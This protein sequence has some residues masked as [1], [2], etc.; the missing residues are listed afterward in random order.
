M[1]QHVTKT[2]HNVFSLNL[3]PIC[4][5][6]IIHI[7]LQ[8]LWIQWFWELPK[9]GCPCDLTQKQVS[10]LGCRHHW[11]EILVSRSLS[12]CRIDEHWEWQTAWE[13]CKPFSWWELTSVHLS[14]FCSQPSPLDHTCV[15]IT[16]LELLSTCVQSWTINKAQDM[17]QC[18]RCSVN[19]GDATMICVGVFLH[20]SLQSFLRVNVFPGKTSYINLSYYMYSQTL[21]KSQSWDNLW[22]VE[23]DTPF[24]VSLAFIY[25]LWS[26]HFCWQ[27]TQRSSSYTSDLYL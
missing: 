21:L 13:H 6:H 2:L 26:A 27:S 8:L 1:D 7:T 3:S 23:P 19:H 22:L 10:W 14:P 24:T 15:A 4:T 17:C 11:N 5:Y 18:G 12:T 9:G 20:L 16:G 25:E